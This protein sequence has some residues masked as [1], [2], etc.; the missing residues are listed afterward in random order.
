MQGFFWDIGFFLQYENLGQIK[1]RVTKQ[2]KI[3]QLDK[4]CIH[5]RV[6][7]ITAKT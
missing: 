6:C 7:T 3:I 2:V 5:V 1:T 4:N